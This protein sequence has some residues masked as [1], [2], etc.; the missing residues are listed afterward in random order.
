[1]SRTVLIKLGVIVAVSAATVFVFLF[2]ENDGLSSHAQTRRP[3]PAATPEPG[4]NAVLRF[5]HDLKP[6]D[7]ECSTCHKF[8]TANWKTVRSKDDAFEDV[9]DYPKHESC[10]SCHQQ[11]FFT[12]S[13][14]AICSI[15]HLAPSPDNSARHPFPNPRELFDSSPKGRSATS[16][17]DVLFPHELH[18][19]IISDQLIR[20]SS[21]SMFIAAAH[22]RPLAENC[23]V[24]HKPMD[25]PGRSSSGPKDTGDTVWSKQGTFMTA[26]LGHTTCFTCHS[27]ASGI[28][29]SPAD[30]AACHK[31]RRE[32]LEPDVTGSFLKRARLDD[33]AM[34]DVWRARRSAGAFRHYLEMH[35][36]MECSACHAV[37]KIDT[38]GRDRRRI[39]IEQCAVCHA[40]AKTSEGGMLNLEIDR[41]TKD[42][43]AECVKCH[44]AYGRSPIP[45]SHLKAVRDAGN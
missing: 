45:E 41:R 15:C 35:R 44:L 1:M 29:P 27:A 11:D 8:P 21:G 19:E 30:C 20:R 43:R 23:S 25:P 39:S 12:G 4:P 32:G 28:D 6:H 16:S 3:R 9:T 7:L 17:F 31:L 33:R 24:C 42:P 13:P 10:L 14:P 2:W 36:D 5:R 38:L 26:P 37:A 22:R 40:T 18:S 34:I